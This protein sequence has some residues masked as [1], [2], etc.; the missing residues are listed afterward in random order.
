MCLKPISP[1]SVFCKTMIVSPM[2]KSSSPKRI[3]ILITST[4]IILL[5]LWFIF[6][7]N[8]QYIRQGGVK[9][10]P[11]GVIFIPRESPLTVSL[12]INPDKLGNFLTQLLPINGEEK[13][14]IRGIEQLRRNLLV[15]A[16]I[17]SPQDIESWLGDEI[18]LGV[19]SLD[20]DYDETNGTQPGYL[21]VVR[22]K[23]PQLA[24]DFLEI[25]YGKQA[26]SDDVELILDTYQGVNIIYQHPLTEEVKIP[27]VA[28]SVVGNFVLF[29]NNLTVLKDAL[30][31]A[32]AVNLSLA[33][34]SRY[35]SAIASLP[36]TKVA[37]AYSNLPLTSAW[38]TN[39][40]KMETV[41]VDQSLALSLSLNPEGLVSHSVLFGVK[42]EENQSPLVN[43]IPPSLSYIPENS[44]LTVT[45][46]NLSQLWQNIKEDKENHNP[47]AEIIYQGIHPMES[48]LQ[49]DFAEEIFPPITGEYAVSLSPNKIDNSLNWLLVKEKGETP[50]IPSLDEIA[51]NRGLTVGELSIENRN[52]VSWTKLVNVVKNRYSRLETEVKGVHT[53]ID[54]YE[55]ITNSLDVLTDI[56]ANPEINLLEYIPFQSSITALPLDNEGYLY[57]KWQ[58]LAP[59]LRRRFPIVKIMELAFK[60]FFSNLDSI[61]VSSEGVKNGVRQGTIFFHL[62]EY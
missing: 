36:K 29:A 48:S 35:Q 25:Y 44:I 12:L 53:E 33:Q 28:A 56:F 19:T 47:L 11:Q 27:E 2:I 5:G 23:S 4:L 62:K 57:L 55:I 1:L 54:N 40:G 20:Y 16:Q 7:T 31:N 10:N 34:D 52:V 8:S 22:N 13:Q 15:K 26:L 45:G 58:E 39:K 42:E 37:I 18:T 14:I 46:F 9:N 41:E 61:T 50:L 38:I 32:Q 21:L 60:P 6:G 3:I 30:N 59:Y 43:Q 51:Q 49:T 17:D 24:R